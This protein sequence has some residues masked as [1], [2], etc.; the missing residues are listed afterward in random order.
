[1]I[2]R[3][4]WLTHGVFA[5]ISKNKF[6]LDGDQSTKFFLCI[7][8]SG[9]VGEKNPERKCLRCAFIHNNRI[10]RFRRTGADPADVFDRKDGK[11]HRCA[12]GWF[13]RKAC[14]KKVDFILPLAYNVI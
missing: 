14:T 4:I 9:A 12:G 8:V 11:R 5:G 6:S 1:M 7:I 3:E 10:R 2:Y 13:R